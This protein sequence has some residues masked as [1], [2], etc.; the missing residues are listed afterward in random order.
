MHMN[1]ILDIII[2]NDRAPETNSTDSF[3]IAV[4]DGRCSKYLASMYS[5]MRYI[6]IILIPKNAG[7][8]ACIIDEDAITDSE[9]DFS[10]RAM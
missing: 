1:S 2:W 8:V 10:S 6:P 5:D 9:W 7:I 4:S 3:V